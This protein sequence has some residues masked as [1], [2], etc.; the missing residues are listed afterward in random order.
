MQL[1][2]E[3]FNKNLE[4]KLMSKEIDFLRRSA[5]F[6]RLEKI[7]NNVLTRKPTQTRSLGRS[8]CR[9][10]DSIGIKLKEIGIS[11][12]NWIGI[13]GEPL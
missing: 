13:I 5:R 11:T 10:E 9:R 2:H 1:K 7:R 12:M 8:R 4:S 3:N 6:S